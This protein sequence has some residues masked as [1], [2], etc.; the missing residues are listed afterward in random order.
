MLPSRTRSQARLWAVI[1]R[2]AAVF[3]LFFAVPS[4]HEVVVDAV[5]LAAG[6][7][8]CDEKACDDEESGHAGSEEGC[9]SS[10]VHGCCA[11]P[12][13]LPPAPHFVLMAPSHDEVAYVW[14]AD[15]PLAEGHHTPPFRPPA[16]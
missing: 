13:A 3:A 7:T 6:V 1:F 2:W 12:V 10:C 15:S 4:V 5:D 9:P 8:C 16:G 11:H 14:P